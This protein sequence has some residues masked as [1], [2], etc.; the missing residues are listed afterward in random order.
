MILKFDQARPAKVLRHRTFVAGP[1]RSGLQPSDSIWIDQP[2]GF[3]PCWYM[4]RLRRFE[5]VAG[6][7]LILIY[8]DSSL[9][10][11]GAQGQGQNDKPK[12]IVSRNSE[13]PHQRPPSESIGNREVARSHSDQSSFA[14][15]LKSHGEPIDSG[16]GQK[17]PHINRM[18]DFAWVKSL[19]SKTLSQPENWSAAQGREWGKNGLTRRRIK[20]PLDL[21]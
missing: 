10:L 21:R 18:E 4:T 2:W 3:A 14:V 8:G 12:T 16:Q 19:Q 20:R 11:R 1:Y 13:T 9:P 15:T 17:Y 5:A 7:S 6:A